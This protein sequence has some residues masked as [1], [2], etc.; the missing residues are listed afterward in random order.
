MRQAT[1][2]MIDAWTRDI[3]RAG[4]DGAGLLAAARALVEKYAAP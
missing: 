4:G 1:Q 2:P 3:D